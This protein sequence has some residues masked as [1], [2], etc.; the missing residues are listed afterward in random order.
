MVDGRVLKNRSSPCD[1]LKLAKRP[2]ISFAFIPLLRIRMN[3]MHVSGNTIWVKFY[4]IGDLDHFP[5]SLRW[6]GPIA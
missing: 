2:H 4:P 1:N 6:Q 3:A 5:L